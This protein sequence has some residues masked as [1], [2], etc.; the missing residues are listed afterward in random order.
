MQL[1]TIISTPTPAL[2][3]VDSTQ[4]LLEERPLLTADDDQLAALTLAYRA[5]QP[6]LAAISRQLF[7]WLDSTTHPLSLFLQAET[8][9]PWAIDF[10]LHSDGLRRVPWELLALQ[11]A[12]PFTPIRRVRAGQQPYTR[13]NRPLRVL[14]MA[15][16][17]RNVKPELDFEAEE[18]NILK[19]VKQISQRADID[20]VVVED[21]SLNGLADE[22][23]AHD[24]G[25]F[26]VVHISGHADVIAGIPRFVM[27]DELGQRRDTTATELADAFN[28]RLPRLIFF[29]GCK[30]AQAPDSGA[31]PSLCESLIQAGA[32]AVLGWAEPV[33]DTHATL[34][35]GELYAQ[36]A[37]GTRLDEAVAHARRELI[38][39]QD[40]YAWLAELKWSPRR[41]SPLGQLQL[42][43]QWLMV[44]RQ[45]TAFA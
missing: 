21:G 26:D 31:L 38:D 33:F 22:V 17:P 8:A 44:W 24:P 14:F 16:S 43:L 20:L 25:Y 19:A 37:V 2:R 7:E 32:T 30:T 9:T 23:T 3:F 15:C 41:R 45:L 42:L 34:M 4:H 39:R 10:N 12:L 5:P 13:A 18:A 36:L 28:G 40:Q 27:E 35:A 1:I 11:R 6:N 29:S